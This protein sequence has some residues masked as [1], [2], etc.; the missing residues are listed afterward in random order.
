MYLHTSRSH[1][2]FLLQFTTW[3]IDDWGS[4]YQ[5][6]CNPVYSAIKVGGG[7]KVDETETEAETRMFTTYEIHSG[8]GNKD[9]SSDDKVTVKVRQVIIRLVIIT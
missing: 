6:H 4:S 3:E 8:F 1:T 2:H 9:F 5:F 7:G